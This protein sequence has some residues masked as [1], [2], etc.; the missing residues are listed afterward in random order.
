MKV[1]LN[2]CK[3]LNQTINHVWQ[4]AVY[5]T[6]K[7]NDSINSILYPSFILFII[8]CKNRFVKVEPLHRKRTLRASSH[9]WINFARITGKPADKSSRCCWSKSLLIAAVEL[10][11]CD[12][13]LS[14]NIPNAGCRKGFSGFSGESIVS[15]MRSSMS[16]ELQ[17]RYAFE[18]RVYFAVQVFKDTKEAISNTSSNHK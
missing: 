10:H 4:F 3:L 12:S 9:P 7:Y 17:I 1:D 15:F 14:K 18:W 8:I 13:S 2:S 5:T 11:A 16:H 6:L